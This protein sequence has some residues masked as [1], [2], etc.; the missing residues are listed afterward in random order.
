MSILVAINHK[1][2]YRFDRSVNLA[3]HTV[4][5]RPA[6]AQPHADPLLLAAHRARGPLHQLA[7]GPLR[8]LRRA[9]GLPEKTDD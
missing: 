1:T 9:A 4:R 6:P 8:Q 5:L 7:A 3:P 2:E